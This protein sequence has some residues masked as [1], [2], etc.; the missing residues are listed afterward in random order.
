MLRDDTEHQADRFRDRQRD[1]AE[2]SQSTWIALAAVSTVGILSIL[3]YLARRVGHQLAVHDLQIR[4]HKLK[5]DYARRQA[6]MA[7]AA[8]KP[9]LF[10]PDGEGEFEIIEDQPRQAA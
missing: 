10:S 4:V 2:F 5:D 3:N 7:E 9:K 1:V 6:E 8:D